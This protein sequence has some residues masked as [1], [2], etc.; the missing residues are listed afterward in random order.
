MF[1]YSD[2]V[3]S[4]FHSLRHLSYRKSSKAPPPPPK[5][6]KKEKEKKR[7]RKKKRG[8]SIILYPLFSLEYDECDDGFAPL[9]SRDLRD[10]KAMFNPVI[11]FHA[12]L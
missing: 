2:G 5:K 7:K 4:V 8:I 10:F 6:K 3:F 1:Q 11:F 9:F 12:N